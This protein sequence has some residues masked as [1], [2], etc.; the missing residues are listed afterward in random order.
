MKNF[1]FTWVP[2]VALGL[3]S[4]TAA[5]GQE[6]EREVEK[7]VRIKIIKNGEVTEIES[8][9][10]SQE[11]EMV[12]LEAGVSPDQMETI[13]VFTSGNHEDVFVMRG[14]NG[15]MEW[16]E[17]GEKKPMLGITFETSKINSQESLVVISTVVEDGAAAEMGLMPGDQ[18]TSINGKPMKSTQDVVDAIVA[19]G[20]EKEITLKVLRDK[21]A[22][23]FTGMLKEGRP[24]MRKEIIVNNHHAM[25]MPMAGGNQFFFEAEENYTSRD[26]KVLEGILGDQYTE[27]IKGGFEISEL[28]GDNFVIMAHDLSTETQLEIYNASGKRMIKMDLSKGD[29]IAETFTL[30]GVVPGIYFATLTQGEEVHTQKFTVK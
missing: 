8:D 28:N 20:L 10:N 9:G 18:I 16:I 11:I 27:S 15:N 24:Q 26:Q 1:A 6:L 4:S 3:F 30:E 5:S 13:E 25:G 7:E 22:Q 14:H 2:F 29:E 12:L 21:K 19:N 23:T 17:E